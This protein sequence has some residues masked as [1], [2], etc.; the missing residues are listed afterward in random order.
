MKSVAQHFRAHGHYWTA[1]VATAIL[2]GLFF[3]SWYNYLLFHS[4]AE[5]FSIVVAC[6]VFAVF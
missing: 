4:F 1:L 6:T 3:A 5:I 2:F